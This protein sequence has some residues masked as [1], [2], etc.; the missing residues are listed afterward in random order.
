MGQEF[1]R[2]YR[3]L[4]AEVLLAFAAGAAAMALGAVAFHGVGSAVLAALLGVSYACAVVGIA[5]WAGIVYAVPV[6]LA[7]LLALDWYYLP[8]IHPFR[9]PG[10]VDLMD[11]V[12]YLVVAVFLGELA[13]HAIRSARDAERARGQIA[14]EQTALRRVATLVAR[15]AP[16]S[17]LFAAVAAEAGQLLDVDGV[18]IGRLED[19]AALTHVAAWT[20]WNRPWPHPPHHDYSDVA[21]RAAFARGADLRAVVEAPVV[22]H[23]RRWGVMVAWSESGSLPADA[24]NR[25]T[26][27]AELVATAIAN[28][29]AELGMARLASEQAA[30]RRVATLVAYGSP[31]EEVFAAVT[32]EVGRLLH[33]G[34]T[35]LACYG[36]DGTVVTVGTWEGTGDAAPVPVGTRWSLGGHNVSTLVFET[37]RTARIDDFA[38]AS[39]PAAELATDLAGGQPVRSIVGAPVSVEGRLWGLIS[40]VSGHEESLPPDAESRLAGFT[41]LVATALANAEAQS[42][43]TASRARIVAAADTARRRFERDLHDGAQQRLVSVALF[44]QTMQRSVLP[45]GE[46][47][48]AQ[49]NRAAAEL[50]GVLDELRELARGLHPA[51]LAEGGLRPAMK[52][53]ARRSAVPV[54]LDVRV[55]GR[56]PEAVEL[57]AYYAVAETLTNTAKHAAASVVDVVVDADGE[58]LTVEVRDDGRGG[59]DPGAGSGLIGLTDRVEALGGRLAV[60]SPPRAGTAVK[61]SVPLGVAEGSQQPVGPRSSAGRSTSPHQESR[62][63]DAEEDGGVLGHLRQD[64]HGPAGGLVNAE[65]A[66]PD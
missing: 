50:S 24:E 38:E 28:S 43:L 11:L 15:G 19:G 3:D 52:T 49:L 37:G 39:G 44:L 46:N 22:V 9:F 2:A 23:G 6:G 63:N 56:L 32:A 36:P 42:A 64:L 45:G 18:R 41:E 47:L 8:P 65:Q 1:T 10:S 33:V 21:E 54:R 14:D 62:G 26:D 25:L 40:V 53:L 13:E 59:A 61:I 51:A 48:T 30:L 29:E 60:S 57:A 17:E 55:D 5:W 4:G 34:V 66:P 7:G 31:P 58:E 27:F 35:M 12:L 20:E 16:A